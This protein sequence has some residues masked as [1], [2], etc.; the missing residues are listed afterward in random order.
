MKV[1]LTVKKPPRVK[2]P[3]RQTTQG[4]ENVENGMVVTFEVEYDTFMSDHELFL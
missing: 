1:P 3:Q 2:C 4:F